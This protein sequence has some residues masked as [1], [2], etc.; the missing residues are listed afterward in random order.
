MNDLNCDHC[1]RKEYE[2]SMSF[3]NDLFVCHNCE[4]E[5]ML[6]NEVYVLR[7][8]NGRLL[9]EFED[10]KDALEEKNFYETETG[11]FA[12]LSIETKPVPD[13]LD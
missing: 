6:D 3:V 2:S 9:G 7:N 10:Q 11:N 13:F 1:G 8:H 4:D 5:I 12:D